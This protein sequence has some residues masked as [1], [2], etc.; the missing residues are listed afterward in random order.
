MNNMNI[1]FNLYRSFYYVAKYDGFTKASYYASLSQSSLSS[2]IKKLEEELGTILFNRKG[3][4]VELTQTGRE[5]YSKLEDI[6]IILQNNTYNKKEIKIGCLRF[7]ADNYLK[8]SITSFVNN[9]PKVK[10]NIEIL[11]NTELLQRLKKDQLDLVIS[12]YPLFYNLDQN[13]TIEKIFDA[14]N[15][16]V[17]SKEY[18]QKVMNK[19]NKE[20]YKYSLILPTSSEKRRNIEQYLIDNN[21]KYEV[22]IEVPNSNLLK[23][24]TQD[25]LGIAYINRKFI[26]KEVNNNNFVILDNFT[27]LPIDNICLL[28]NSKKIDTITKEYIDEL[29]KS[30]EKTDS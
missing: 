8:E 2:N 21:I 1:N 19:M 12:R 26:L 27:K 7:I 3:S 29:K 25:G 16:F 9:N 28:Y 13:I 20:D 30:I 11:D 17:C 5:L 18:Y 14:E 22:V 24:L 10:I 23:Q 6:I 15:V 4:K